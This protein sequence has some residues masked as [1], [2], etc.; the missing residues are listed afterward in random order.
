MAEWAASWK[1]IIAWTILFVGA[2][3]VFLAT[4]H[5]RLDTPLLRDTSPELRSVCYFLVAL[6]AGAF[7][8]RDWSSLGPDLAAKR[9]LVA[10]MAAWVIIVP[11]GAFILP[12][13][14]PLWF[15]GLCGLG[16]SVAYFVYVNSMSRLHYPMNAVASLVVLF[17]FW[18]LAWYGRGAFLQ[19]EEVMVTVVICGVVFWTVQSFMTF[20]A[21]VLMDA[22]ETWPGVTVVDKDSTEFRDK[23]D[24]FELACAAYPQMYPF[25]LHMVNL[26][27]VE[28]SNNSFTRSRS[29]FDNTL[30][31]SSTQNIRQLYH[32]TP[33]QSSRGIIEKGFRLPSKAGMF[34]K[35]IYFADCPL[36]SWGYTDGVMWVKNGFILSCQVDLGRPKHEKQARNDL[37]RPPH[38]TFRQ[39]LRGEERYESVVGDDKGSGGSLR[40]PEYVV[41]D[42]GRIKIEYICEVRCVP[43]GTPETDD[44]PHP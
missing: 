14:G 37:E 42:S 3:L 40:L 25:W 43:A 44:G 22:I 31:R 19:L 10:G 27:R 11:F 9:A 2:V 13:L 4:H 15:F 28:V 18:G 34:G 16:A 12:F 33:K 1:P 32:G 39:W 6:T 20:S 36:K 38:R 29:S 30:T 24:E 7:V 23:K 41:Y 17:A 5:G 26:Y 21:E 35:G 8:Y